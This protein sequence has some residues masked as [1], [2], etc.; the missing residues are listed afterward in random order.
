MTDVLLAGPNE[1]YRLADRLRDQDGLAHKVLKDWAPTEAATKH[2]GPRAAHGITDALAGY[3]PTIWLFATRF[4][5]YIVFGLT[6]LCRIIFRA[7]LLL[8]AT[9]LATRLFGPYCSDATKTQQHD[10]NSGDC[11]HD[12]LL[13]MHPTTWRIIEYLTLHNF[14]HGAI[15]FAV[16]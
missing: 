1:L 15:K 10:D 9:L 8:I 6:C 5:A 14:F 7:G 4:H 13:S 12:D 11:S 16:I 3:R 2:H